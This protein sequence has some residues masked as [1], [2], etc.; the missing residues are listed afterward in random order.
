[1]VP[2]AAAEWTEDGARRE[3]RLDL[4]CEVQAAAALDVMER[5]LARAIASEQER[6]RRFVPE[7]DPEHPADHELLF[8]LDLTRERL[9]KA[10]GAKW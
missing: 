5:L 4:A 2:E 1:M 8:R 10:L 7:R 6:A 9:F 3:Q